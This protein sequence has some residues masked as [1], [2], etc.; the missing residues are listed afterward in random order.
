MK[1]ENE[2]KSPFLEDNILV[3][4]IIKDSLNNND[5]LL[6]NRKYDNIK[7]I[8]EKLLKQSL[9]ERINIC[10]KSAKNQLIKIN[11]TLEITKSITNLA[12]KMG[13]QIEEKLKKEKEKE[14]KYSKLK[15]NKYNRGGYK[16]GISPHKSAAGNYNSSYYRNKTPS[17]INK[18]GNN[19]RKEI[20][21]LKRELTKSKSNMTLIKKDKK[22]EVIGNNKTNRRSNVL[23][24]TMGNKT[25]S[26]INFKKYINVTEKN[27]D[28]LQTISVTSIKTNKTNTTTLN[29]I[30]NSGHNKYPFMKNSRN[31]KKQSIGL[32]LRDNYN[33]FKDS[34]GSKIQ[35]KKNLNNL[36]LSE[37]DLISFNNKRTLL[38][39]DNSNNIE[40]KKRRKKTP[41]KKSKTTI[42]SNENARSIINGNKKKEKSIEDEIDDILSMECNLQKETGLNNNDPL[43]I[44]PLKDLDFV[45]KGLLRKYS[46]RNER[47]INREKSYQLKTFNILQNFENLKFKNIFKYLSLYELLSIKNISKKFH[48]LIILYMI[49]HLEKERREI[50]EIKDNLNVREK[51]QRE[52]I[53]KIIL[54][55]GSKKAAQLLNESQLN[56]LFK[57][58]KL[59][60]YDIILIYRIYFQ[61]INHPFSLVA[62]TD[63][64]QFWEKCKYYFINEENGKTG[65][66][67]LGLINKKRV[68]ISKNNL[69]QIYNLVKGNWDK[70]IPNYFSSICGTTGLFVFIIKDILEFLGIS[71]KIK[72]RENAYWTYLD[73]LDTINDKIN[74]LQNI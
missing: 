61:I 8:L 73:I 9:D 31:L 52:D 65:D 3:P 41:F 55:K 51:P 12:L 14:K 57:D 39:S 60:I 21:S 20:V 15:I 7:K 54:S 47:N 2:I 58:E 6:E 32:T 62:K 45:P 28:D 70:I 53:S 11:T 22:M 37:K 40:E 68:D 10:E 18:I 69:Y 33:K 42:I 48:K 5:C 30:S 16:K 38:T 46:V 74:Y 59:P 27:V 24:K 13:K 1:I 34:R 26:S 44:L 72:K 35:K 25:K 66:I 4:S 71:K 29:T 63:I 17:H 50:S 64:N 43:L 49:E 36:T 19:N 56:H 67:L 23:H